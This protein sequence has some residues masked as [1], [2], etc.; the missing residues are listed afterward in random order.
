MSIG[1]YRHNTYG[2][3]LQN[4]STGLQLFWDDFFHTKNPSETW[5]HPPTAIV[6][7]DFFYLH[8]HLPQLFSLQFKSLQVILRQIQF[9]NVNNCTM[10][11]DEI[12]SIGNG[13]NSGQ[14]PLAQGDG[15]ALQR[16]RDGCLAILR[17]H[18]NDE[19]MCIS[20]TYQ[21]TF[22]IL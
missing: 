9:Q 5:T 10:S 22:Q 18:T 21:P 14:N 6:I 20:T 11:I 17:H 16:P 7:S 4:I 19:I 8:S 1:A 15:C 2:I 13:N 3:L 12:I